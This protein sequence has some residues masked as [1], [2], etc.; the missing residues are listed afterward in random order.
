MGHGA[1]PAC[2]RR[3][4]YTAKTAD[5]LRLTYRNIDNLRIYHCVS[6][7]VV[8]KVQN[9][10]LG[11]S[12]VS[13]DQFYHAA[14]A[15]FWNKYLPAVRRFRR[16]PCLGKSCGCIFP[17]IRDILG[18]CKPDEK[19]QYILFISLLLSAIFGILLLFS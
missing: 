6:A 18:F 10:G 19:Y 13:R 2:Y 11:W 16:G 14:R 15:Q 12:R 3:R 1:R 7:G 4:V 17:S 8:S 5:G 9:S